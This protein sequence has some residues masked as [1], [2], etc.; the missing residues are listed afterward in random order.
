[1]TLRQSKSHWKL[2]HELDNK[3]LAL[4]LMALQTF[5]EPSRE[6][7]NNFQKGFKLSKANSQTDEKLL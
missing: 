3:L 4:Q 7:E 2:N 5:K 1:M 6:R